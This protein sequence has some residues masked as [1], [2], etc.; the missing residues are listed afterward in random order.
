MPRR[1]NLSTIPLVLAMALC[2]IEAAPSARDTL[3]R[4][5]GFYIGTTGHIDEKKA[6]ELF[7]KAAE[8][9]DPLARMWV[10]RCYYRARCR[11]PRD[12]ERAQ[13]MAKDVIG[14]VQR[15]AEGGDSLAVFLLA[16]AFQEGLGLEKDHAKAVEWYQKAAA[17]GDAIAMGNLGGM[18]KNGVW[19]AKSYKKALEWYRKAAEAGNSNAMNALGGMYEEGLGVAVDYDQ[20]LVWYRKAL[21]KKNAGAV[22]NIGL[23]YQHGLGLPQSYE[24]ALKWYR[25]AAEMGS[26]WGMHNS[27]YMY[28]MGRGVEKDYQKALEWYLKAADNDLAR[29]MF[30]IAGMYKTGQGV[31]RNQVQA[32]EWYRKAAE[33]GHVESTFRIGQRYRDGDGLPQDDVEAVKWYRKAVERGHIGALGALG[34]MYERGRGVEKDYEEAMRWYAKGAELGDAYCIGGMG[35]LYEDGHGVEKDLQRAM[36]LYER[37]L[38]LR[39]YE[40]ARRGLKRVKRKLAAKQREA[41]KVTEAIGKPEQEVEIDKVAARVKD[42]AREGVEWLIY[43]K[44][45]VAR[46]EGAKLQSFAEFLLVRDLEEIKVNNLAFLAD[47]VWVATGIGAF[48][49][50]RNT[51]GW[52]EYAVNREHIGMPVDSISVD[53]GDVITFKMKVDG[54]EK[55]YTLNTK[56]SEW[57]E[58][59]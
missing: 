44:K 19:V 54:K 52:V 15:L 58:T 6:R 12:P 43:E 24:M 31:E 4:A 35:T 27:G 40:W 8:T 13:S 10:A 23:M 9:G 32:A 7:N 1:L 50:E 25:K 33:N 5:I 49:Y 11:F 36:T 18:Y 16:S 2:Q 29:S 46:V 37:S 47:S 28:H 42:T 56:T 20:A 48:C 57:A 17:A 26:R 34:N 21:A 59:K 22:K 53:A 30:N 3:V 39:R 41:V 38:Q 45:F 55:V 51:G 14:D